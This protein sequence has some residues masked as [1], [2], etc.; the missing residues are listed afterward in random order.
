VWHALLLEADNAHA[1]ADAVLG[2]PL[3]WAPIIWAAIAMTEYVTVV[4][5]LLGPPT[6]TAQPPDEGTP[7]H[8]RASLPMPP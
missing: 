1:A 8:A 2:S 5:G 6:E 4:E 3:H 7:L